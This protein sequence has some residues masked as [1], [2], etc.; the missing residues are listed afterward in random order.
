MLF[1]VCAPHFVAGLVTEDSVAQVQAPI[2]GYM[3]GWHIGR[4]RDYARSKG[5]RIQPVA[6]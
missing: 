4:V 6:S 2:L 5:W 3:H 1:R